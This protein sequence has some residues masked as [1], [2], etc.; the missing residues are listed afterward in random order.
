[1]DDADLCEEVTDVSFMVPSANE[2]FVTL[3]N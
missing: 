1:M 2:D 3:L